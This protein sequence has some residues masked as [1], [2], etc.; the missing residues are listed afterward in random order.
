LLTRDRLEAVKNEIAS[1]AAGYPGNKA[2]P[3]SEIHEATP[4]TREK[5][6]KRSKFK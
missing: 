4:T 2:Y 6:L 1:I 5:L 3:K